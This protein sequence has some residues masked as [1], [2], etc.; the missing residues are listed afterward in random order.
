CYADLAVDSDPSPP[1][2]TTISTCTS[3]TDV[4]SILSDAMKILYSR[5]EEEKF[6]GN[7]ISSTQQ[8]TIIE[9][10]LESIYSSI[11]LFDADALNT[12]SLSDNSIF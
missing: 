4:S 3:N 7:I 6:P 8:K 10:H 1:S 9:K 2:P 5:N 12:N 11:P